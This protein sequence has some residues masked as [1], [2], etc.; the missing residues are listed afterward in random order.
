MDRRETYGNLLDVQGIVL[1]HV[2][3]S[4]DGE[5]VVGLLVDFIDNLCFS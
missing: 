1:T 5:L 2:G 3:R 4:S